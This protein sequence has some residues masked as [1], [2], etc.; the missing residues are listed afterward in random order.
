MNQEREDPL[1]REGRWEA[2]FVGGCWLAALVFTVGYC[3]W[4]GYER[5][6]ESLRFV[7]GFPD[8]VFWGII[9][10][11]GFWTIVALWFARTWMKD[12]PL[13]EADDN[14]PQSAGQP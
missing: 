12:H 4:Y 14:P 10:P 7:C 5:P 1:V 6:I 8:W 11:W 13:E 3:R 9:V 2:L